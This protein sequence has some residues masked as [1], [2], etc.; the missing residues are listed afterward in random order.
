M[1]NSMSVV[2][3]AYRS[4]PG[5]FQRPGA[6]R[7]DLLYGLQLA[8]VDQF[9]RCAEALRSGKED[10]DGLDESEALPKVSPPIS[11]PC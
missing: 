3:Q 2:T 5:G 8:F 11:W 4:Q 9:D 1:T 6:K 7:I 10:D